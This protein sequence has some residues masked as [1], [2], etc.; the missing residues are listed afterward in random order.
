M[1]QYTWGDDD[2]PTSRLEALLE[3]VL[4]TPFE[5]IK[6]VLNVVLGPQRMQRWT[7]GGSDN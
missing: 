6:R 4:I 1:S 7:R 2:E 3:L 5:V